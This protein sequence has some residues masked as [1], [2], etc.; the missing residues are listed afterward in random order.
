METIKNIIYALR[1]SST[2][3]KEW[4]ERQCEECV[5]GTRQEMDGE[6]WIACDCDRIGMDAAEALEKL[7]EGQ[8][9]G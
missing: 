5:Y 9:N 3:P 6:E 1:C 8:S 4:G 7:T 2:P